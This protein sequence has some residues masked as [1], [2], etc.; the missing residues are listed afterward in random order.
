MFAFVVVALNSGAKVRL[1]TFT[2]WERLTF[3]VHKDRRYNDKSKKASVVSRSMSGYHTYKQTSH[4]A[5][6]RSRLIPCLMVVVVVD[7]AE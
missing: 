7:I 4:H 3:F 2:R 6:W 5:R 1:R